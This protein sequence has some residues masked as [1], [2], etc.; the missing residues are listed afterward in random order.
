[1]KKLSFLLMIPLLLFSVI[2]K[3][4]TTTSYDLRDG[5][6]FNNSNP[7][8]QTTS[9]DG[10]LR[11]QAATTQYHSTGYG[12]VFKNNNS[13][14]VDVAEGKNTIRFYG[15][16]YSAGTMNGGSTL[17]GNDLG[18]QNVLVAIDKTGY[19]EFTYTGGAI[20]LY[21]T[22]I[23]ANAYTPIIDVTHEMVLIT[24]TDVW[25]FGAQQ[26]DP[27][28]YNNMLTESVINSFYTYTTP[29]IPGQSGRNLPS[30]TAGDFGYV[31]N[32]TTSDRLRTSNLN[33]TRWDE[34]IASSTKFTGRLYVN[35]GGNVNRYLTLNLNEDDEVTLETR[36]DGGG[37]YHFKYVA[38]PL[39]QTD[40]IEVPAAETTVKL[41]AKSAGLYHITDVV[42]KPSYFRV[43]RKAAQYV[44]LTGN[45]N[46]TNAPGI[47]SGYSI[48]FTNEAGKTWSAVV[49][50]GT[51]T[52]N[53]PVEYTYT[54]SLGDANGYVIASALTLNATETTTNFDVTVLQV[55]LFTV[56]GNITG[57]SDLSNLVLSYTPDPLA[58]KI[59]NPIVSI[60]TGASTYSVDLEANVE[61]TIS[62][63]GVND[64][65]ILAN[66]ITITGAQSA[67]INFTPKP[68]YNVTINTPDLNATQKSKLSL[69][70][71]NL[72]ETGYSYN[73]TDANAVVLRDG[74]Y[75]VSYS[76]LDEYAI[77]M[78]LTSNLTIA[79]SNTSKDLAFK[80][81]TEWVFKDR[82]ITAATAYKGLLFTGSVNV[83]GL[84]NGDL[85]ASS[86][87]TIS[88]PVQ[89]GDKLLITD[90]YQSNYS[91]DGGATI[92][93]TS[94]STSTRITTKYVYPGVSDGMVTLT[95]G[96]SSYFVSIKVLQIVPYSATITVGTG[97]DYQTINE[98]LNAISRM[99]RPSNE[100]VT[101]LIDPGNY[102]EMLVISSPNVTLKNA[103]SSPSIALL[104]KGIDIDA[105]A[106][107]ITSYYGQKY[108]F[109]SQGTDNK[110][111]ADVL[112]VNTANGYTEYVN[113]EGTGGGSSYWNATV[114][115][116]STG[117]TAE[118]IIL[119]NSF[120]QYISLKESQDEVQPKGGDPIRPTNYG[121]ISVQDRSAGYVTQAAAIGIAAS[122]DKVVLNNCR[123]IGRQ[124]S[125]YGAAPARVVIY[126]GAVMGAVDYLFGAMNAV[127]YK[128]DLVLNT[129]DSNSDVA[130]IT[131]AQQSSGRGYLMYQCHVKSPV[132]GIE[133]ASING[134]KPG[135]FGRPWSP[136]T[137]EVVF[138]ETTI[139]A[140][141]YPDNVGQSLIVPVGWNNTLGGT[142]PYMYE[143]STMELS[144]EN[145]SASRAAWSTILS[146]DQLTDGTPITT[147]NFTK[148]NDNW[149][150]IA[151]LNSLSVDDI[152][153]TSSK[154]N[155]AAYGGKVYIS[156]VKSNTQINIYNITGALVKS[157]AT[158]NDTNFDFINGLFIVKIKDADGKKTVKLIAH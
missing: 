1:M 102:E 70:F 151:E 69:T 152:I 27:V 147:F 25:D 16:V 49:S 38:D 79:G 98:A 133:T 125:F 153:K 83:R 55:D 23:G 76:G 87:A 36:T 72:N 58:N 81:I 52:I 124:D 31:T 158:K 41:V 56:S 35:S 50:S 119:E 33:V 7:I 115:V 40:I 21:F 156:N 111:H 42:G 135:Y 74:A 18:S 80:P 85:L 14:E 108:N 10:K 100:R 54:V 67:D 43:Y 116:E 48:N 24:K 89:V 61:Y 105:N 22:F 121:N 92:N 65:E 39:A 97:K 117:F 45:V 120:N 137:S 93:N 91:I 34:N 134:S 139:D 6:T 86:G 75:S 8:T 109:F 13:L 112:A 64:Y 129:S 32:S 113:Q 29:Q 122:A 11:T 101:V 104:N 132:P 57:L 145:N 68:V 140:S 88:I 78:A 71:K 149:D 59:Y 131:A 103:A 3:G 96:G 138:F 95:T 155:L 19:Y 60:N 114:V 82:S 130:Y 51:Y 126:K 144:G 99:D 128:T 28:L 84:S 150:P 146:Q 94:N 73:F 106:V 118:D 2:V 66:T 141:T 127:F 15:S 157:I 47:P 90:Y 62:A 136:N 107:R 17:G 46:E 20:T 142:S 44:S 12:V 123:V 148:G 63:Q 4:Q 53:L 5:S 9:P 143:R 77:E 110:W 37:I 30:F 154:V 26:L